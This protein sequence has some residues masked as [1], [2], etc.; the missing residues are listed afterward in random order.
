MKASISLLSFNCPIV[1]ITK[2]QLFP[3]NVSYNV[4][5]DVSL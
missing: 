4:A 3:Y 2:L 5:V 1:V